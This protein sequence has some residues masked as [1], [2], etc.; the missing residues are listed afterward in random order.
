MKNALR[1]EI[2]APQR[3]ISSRLISSSLGEGRIAAQFHHIDMTRSALAALSRRF[4]LDVL[5][6]AG[7]PL[8]AHF[9]IPWVGF[10]DD[11]QYKYFP[12]YYTAAFRAKRDRFLA[13]MACEPKAVIM[14]S[15]NAADDARKF[16]PHLEAEMVPIPFAA[17]PAEDWLVEQLGVARQYGVGPRYFMISN[18]FWVSKRHRVAFAAFERLAREDEGVQLVC[19]GRIE[20][21]RDPGHF[22]GLLKFIADHDLAKRICILGFIP[23]LDQIALMKRCIAVIQATE[24]EGTPGGLSIYDAISLGVRTIVS[25]IPVNREIEEWVTSYFP[26]NDIDALYHTMSQ[27]MRSSA[28]SPNTET[29]RKL[30]RERRLRCAEAL[31]GAARLAMGR[32]SP[33]AFSDQAV[34]TLPTEE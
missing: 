13:R 30:G 26:L 17:A 33:N 9:P 28:P 27:M 18:Q 22:P 3:W 24:F 15:R 1:G 11:F 10:I 7:F 20:D 16:L 21:H 4:G 29:L 32:Q 19:T 2:R 31:L 14:L 23:K 34:P 5:L 25:D 6:P 12:Q 8:G